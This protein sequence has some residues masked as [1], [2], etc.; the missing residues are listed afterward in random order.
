M[1][2]GNRIKVI[3][4]SEVR[5]CHKVGVARTVTIPA[6]NEIII[7]STVGGKRLLRGA[8]QCWNQLEVYS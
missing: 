3:D 8:P 5:V 7:D 6:G 1:I 2:G 4:R